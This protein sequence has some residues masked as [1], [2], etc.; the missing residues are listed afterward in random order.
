MRP[1]SLEAQWQ[2]AQPVPG[3]K[4]VK[5]YEP[6]HMYLDTILLYRVDFRKFHS[7][8]QAGG[9]PQSQLTRISRCLLPVTPPAEGPASK[10]AYDV[11]EVPMAILEHKKHN[12]QS[13]SRAP[14]V[15]LAMQMVSAVMQYSA[16][17]LQM[18]QFSVF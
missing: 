6:D 1:Y 16:L 10:G 11:L 8:T 12:T 14:A 3:T 4:V 7:G 13:S 5:K 15:Q 18:Y 2:L 17:K 9:V